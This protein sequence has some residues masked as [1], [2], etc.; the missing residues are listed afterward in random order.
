[1][2]VLIVENMTH[3]FCSRAILE[4]ASFRLQKEEHVV[5]VGD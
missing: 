4:D 2:S 1:M 5:L 3:G